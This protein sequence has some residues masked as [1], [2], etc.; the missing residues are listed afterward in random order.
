MLKKQKTREYSLKD[1]VSVL[2]PRIDRS[3]VDFQR[4]PGIICSIS[5]HN[6]EIFYKILTVY[7]ILNDSYRV[8]DLEPFFGLVEVD[9]ENYESKY[10]K[11]SLTAAAEVHSARLGSLI[12]VING[13]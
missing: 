6:G 9:L 7:G 2:I 12:V 10:Q 4:F 8:S 3:G 5:N 11:I 1:L 13:C